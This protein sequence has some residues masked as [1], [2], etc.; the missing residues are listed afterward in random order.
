M[1]FRLAV[2][3][4]NASCNSLVGQVDVGSTNSTGQILIYT[5]AQPATPATAASGTLLVTINF[6][7]PSFGASSAGVSTMATGTAV[8]A[9]VT[10]TGTAGWFRVQNRAV[11]AVFDGA[12]AT[13][14]SDM[15]FDNVSFVSGG[16]ATITSMTITVP[17]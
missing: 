7:N 5:G 12:I 1:A 16:T 14:A 17:M 15:N 4:Q 8:S 11:A 10:A 3:A 9:S 2:I 13:S 6:N